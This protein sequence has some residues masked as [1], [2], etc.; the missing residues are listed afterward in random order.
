MGDVTQRPLLLPTTVFPV[1]AEGHLGGDLPALAT[2]ELEAKML[3]V[4]GLTVIQDATLTRYSLMGRE[5][6]ERVQW[7]LPF[8]M[9]WWDV[10][11]LPAE[12]N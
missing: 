6:A 7:T 9:Y 10:E 1:R 2:T 11:P 12:V 8:G 4:Y 5:N 3:T